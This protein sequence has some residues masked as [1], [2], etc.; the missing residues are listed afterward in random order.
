MRTVNFIEAVQSGLSFR[1]I[2]DDVSMDLRSM[3]RYFNDCL[4]NEDT[5]E[6]WK[7]IK[8]AINDRYVLIE[9]SVNITA[10]D[11]EEAYRKTKSKPYPFRIEYLKEELGL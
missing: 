8:Y 3:V 1:S 5:K 10:S 11:L 9:N 6:A 7:S 4:E 2:S